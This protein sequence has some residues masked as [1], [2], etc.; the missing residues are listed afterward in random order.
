MPRLMI[1]ASSVFEI[2]C[3]KKRQTNGYEN[4]KTLIG[5]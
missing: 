1:L 3:G 4:S 2:S 5:D